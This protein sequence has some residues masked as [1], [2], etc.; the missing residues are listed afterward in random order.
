MGWD[1][2][3]EPNKKNL[4]PNKKNLEPNKKN[5]RRSCSSPCSII[6][7]GPTEPNKNK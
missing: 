6:E 4:E 5:L 1:I 7:S 3:I 2:P